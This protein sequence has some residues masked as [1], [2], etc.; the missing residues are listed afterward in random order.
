MCVTVSSKRRLLFHEDSKHIRSRHT[1]THARARA[2]D[3]AT[4]PEQRA[5]FVQTDARVGLTRAD[6]E[7]AVA[8]LSSDDGVFE[9]LVDN[10][11]ASTAASKLVVVSAAEIS[12]A[13]FLSSTAIEHDWR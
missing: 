13:N 11:A 3:A 2:Q 5:R 10:G 8:I 4:T 9:E 6:V 7:H 12:H 1:H